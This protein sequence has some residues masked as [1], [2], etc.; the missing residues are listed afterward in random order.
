MRKLKRK[1]GLVGVASATAVVLL[2]VSACSSSSGS[3]TADNGKTSGGKC[4]GTSRTYTFAFTGPLSGPVAPF[5]APAQQGLN[6]YFTYLNTK[7]GVNCH[8]LKLE[9]TDI[10]TDTGQAVAAYRQYVSNPAVLAITGLG[11]SSQVE[12]IAPSLSTDGIAAISITS[13]DPALLPYNKWYFSFGDAL[14]GEG[15]ASLS[16]VLSK[17]PHARIAFFSYDTP[18][19]VSLANS[20]ASEVKH[21]TAKLVY[22]TLV[23]FTASNVSIE[24]ANLLKTKPNWIING[25][26]TAPIATSAIDSLKTDGFKGKMIVVAAGGDDSDFQLGGNSSFT[27]VATRNFRDPSETQIPAV[28]Q[29]MAHVSGPHPTVQYYTSGWV[30]GEVIASALKICGSS[31][32]RS[33]FRN[34]LEKVNL[35]NAD[36]L[37]GGPVGF[38]STCHQG[39]RTA[40]IYVWNPTTKKPQF[41]ESKP[42]YT[43]GPCAG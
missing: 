22:S 9:S 38:S 11:I 42:Y 10:S 30:L 32:S 1:E 39:F 5:I 3:S 36:G 6:N 27:Y 24:I 21:S 18:A 26:A 23:P 16:Y 20:I 28:A 37:A 2:L 4:S 19:E 17:D 7:G 35:G 33:A 29:M 13:G 31:C 25:G 14:A 40:M 8:Q 41:D 34:A 12:P 43:S 15:T